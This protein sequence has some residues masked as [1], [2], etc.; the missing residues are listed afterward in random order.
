VIEMPSAVRGNCVNGIYHV[1]QRGNNREYLFS[2]DETK[3][4]LIHIINDFKIKFDFNLLGFVIMDNH[5]HFLIK[6]NNDPLNEIMF[7]IN[8]LF[9]H[10]LNKALGRSGHIYGT[11]YKSE[12]V[13]SDS[14]L[15]WLLR[16]IH[17][18]PIRA[19]IVAKVDDYKW[20]SHYSYKKGINDTVNTDY[21]LGIVSSKRAQGIL[22]YMKFIDADNNDD[23]YE[24]YKNKYEK[25]TLGNLS[26][27]IETLTIDKKIER[28]SLQDLAS[29]ILIDEDKKALVFAGSKQRELTSI[30]LDFIKEAILLKYT[31]KE[32]AVYLNSSESMVRTILARHKS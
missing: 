13:D 24:E 14:Y 30:K 7:S 11:R 5:Y 8:N 25:F 17:R 26:N 12:Y 23:N 15:L 22:K 3:G 2:K 18:N 4:M 10:Y 29:L 32:I 19:K 27:N 16:Y 31:Y 6:V 1:F 28:K 21:I 9:A 20:S